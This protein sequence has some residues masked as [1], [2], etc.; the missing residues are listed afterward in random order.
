MAGLQS[1]PSDYSPRA[2]RLSPDLTTAQYRCSSCMTAIEVRH[3]ADEVV[4]HR[5]RF[6]EHHS[7]FTGVTAF[8]GRITLGNTR[9]SMPCQRRCGGK[10]CTTSWS[11]HERPAGIPRAHA[12]VR[13]PHLHPCGSYVKLRSAFRLR[14]SVWQLPIF[15]SGSSTSPLVGHG[16]PS[17]I[18]ISARPST[19][20]YIRLDNRP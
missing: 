18:E 10:A 2:P 20:F 12:E 17:G 19:E 6:H 16:S 11:C 13:L 8:Q 1:S 4:S 14:F 15:H 9:P 5:T 7:F 3:D